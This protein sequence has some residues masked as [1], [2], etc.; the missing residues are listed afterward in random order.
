MEFGS[1][2]WKIFYDSSTNAIWLVIVFPGFAVPHVNSTSNVSAVVVST[3]VVPVWTIPIIAPELCVSRY[4]APVV[5]VP[6]API[7]LHA[8]SPSM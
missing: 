8:I 3:V 2:C 5:T 6:D 4:W 7:D 1:L